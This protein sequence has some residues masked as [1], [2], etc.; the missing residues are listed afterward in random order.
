MGH[1]PTK[2][3][4][5]GDADSGVEDKTAG[6]AIPIVSVAVDDTH[7]KDGQVGCGHEE[8]EERGGKGIAGSNDFKADGVAGGEGERL[9]HV[10]A[11]N[12]Q[13]EAPRGAGQ[14]KE[15]EGEDAAG[16]SDAEIEGAK[17]EMASQGLEE[18]TASEAGRH[19]ANAGKHAYHAFAGGEVFAYA[20]QHV[21]EGEGGAGKQE[22]GQGDENFALLEEGR[23]LSPEAAKAFARKAAVGAGRGDGEEEEHGEHHC[24]SHEAGGD[25]G[26]KAANDTA[27]EKDHE[28]GGARIGDGEPH[29][30]LAVLVLGDEAAGPAADG[31]LIEG[32][33][34]I[35][36][37]HDGFNQNGLAMVDDG[38]AGS[39]RGENSEEDGVG[40]AA[41]AHIE[42]GGK[43]ETPETGRQNGSDNDSD[44]SPGHPLR[45]QHLRY[46]DHGESADEAEE[47]IGKAHE[48]G[49]GQAP[50][51][52]H[53]ISLGVLGVHSRQKGRR[54]RIPSVVPEGWAI[55]KRDG[56]QRARLRAEGRSRRE[57]PTM[58]VVPLPLV[59]QL[60]AQKRGDA[61]ALGGIRSFDN[62]RAGTHRI[63]APKALALWHLAS[64]DAASVAVAWSL[65]FAWVAGVRLPPWTPM[66]LA[67]VA[68]TVYVGDR[69]L[70]ARAN[71]RRGDLDQLCERHYFHWRH[72]YVLVP[73]AAG[74]ALAAA[75]IIWIAMPRG[76]L[77][78]NTMLGAAA[79][80]YF[81]GVHAR[82]KLPRLLTKEFLVGVIFTAACALPAWL[83]MRAPVAPLW[84]FGGVAAY[85]GALAWL[86]CYAIAQWESGR[87]ELARLARVRRLGAALALAGLLLA[88]F[89]TPA[90]ARAGALL[91]AGAASALLL[92]LLDRERDR[93]TPLALRALADFVLLTPLLMAP[94]AHLAL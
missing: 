66:L 12:S 71:L 27:G 36:G 42:H 60:P 20:A 85:F 65:A 63:H 90:D 16:D 92:A 64:L 83:R 45:S 13:A 22:E 14:S 31:T 56:Q 33:R 26:R 91:V 19:G 2:R 89:V 38:K 43:E 70:D 88:C 74:T 1:Y 62:G 72:R 8:G 53:P 69:L 51:C 23:D 18:E 73:L 68:W 47:G 82:R 25:D 37:D 24:A 52:G 29:A 11:G 6:D 41:E 57:S 58:E 78:P 76:A 54:R 32:G 81:S 77:A 93:L 46:G 7:V 48:P 80:A 10:F 75:S 9:K 59:Q 5:D 79:F 28:A 44:V 94:L 67:L 87:A 61:Q 17:A 49:W 15:T 21:G 55:S 4:A 84:A 39:G 50:G 35:C 34:Q 30:E 40:S 3:H 86:N